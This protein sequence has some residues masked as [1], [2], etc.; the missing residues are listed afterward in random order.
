MALLLPIVQSNSRLGRDPVTS[1]KEKPTK[2]LWGGAF[3][4]SCNLKLK[5]TKIDIKITQLCENIVRN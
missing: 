2:Y 1:S 3:C 5:L 4:L